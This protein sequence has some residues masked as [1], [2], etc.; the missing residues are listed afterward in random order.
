MFLRCLIAGFA[1]LVSLPAMAQMPRF[2]LAAGIHRIDAEVAY[3]DPMRQQG[4]MN[5]QSMASHQGMLFVFSVDERHCMW[6]RNTFIPLSV[7]FLD[8]QGRIL[9]IEDMKP[10]TDDSHCAA[11]PARFALEMN[12]GWFAARG[13]KPGLRIGGLDKLPKPR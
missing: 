8:A 6:M 1:L 7:A 13:L 5:R 3:T 12:R 11:N 4:L 9:N 10:Q 2:D